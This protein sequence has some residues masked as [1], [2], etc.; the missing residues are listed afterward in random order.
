MCLH[1]FFE[2]V[3][4]RACTESAQLFQQSLNQGVLPNDWRTANVAPVFKKGKRSLAGNYRPISCT[5]INYLQS[6]GAC[7]LPPYLGTLREP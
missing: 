4:S 2:L 6:L 5:N 7:H 1:V 3:H